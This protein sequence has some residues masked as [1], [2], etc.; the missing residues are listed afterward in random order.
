MILFYL[1]LNR[2]NIPLTRKN[3]FYRDN[4]TCQ[5]CG[6]SKCQ[7][8]IDHIIPKHKGG[9][10]NWKNLVTSCNRCNSK[11]GNFYIEELGMKLIKKPIRPHYLMYLQKF[12]LNEY[13]NWKPYL[14]MENKN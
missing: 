4:N 8:T 5:Y 9:E 13:N 12:A 1:Y 7:L 2:K 6:K 3:I 14:F 10:D 11:K